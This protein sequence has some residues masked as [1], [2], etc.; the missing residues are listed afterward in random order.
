MSSNNG[1]LYNGTEH[2]GGV[3]ACTNCLF[4][5][6]CDGDHLTSLQWHISGCTLVWQSS[7]KFESAVLCFSAACALG[8]SSPQSALD[9][10]GPG[11]KVWPPSRQ[12]VL[13]SAVCS[14][15]SSRSQWLRGYA[16][17]FS[18]FVKLPHGLHVLYLGP[19]RL[20]CDV[21]FTQFYFHSVS[22]LSIKTLWAL[23]V[24]RP[25]R[26]QTAFLCCMRNAT[27]SSLCFIRLLSN[28]DKG[29]NDPFVR[30]QPSAPL[31]CGFICFRNLKVKIV[32]I[33][34]KKCC[35]FATRYFQCARFPFCMMWFWRQKS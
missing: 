2:W 23:I 22:I 8:T 3:S 20:H 13:W 33:K 1:R 19:L 29:G 5:L 10:L 4:P 30:L 34:R 18:P 9:R 25:S 27:E 14:T 12:G 6:G 21:R 24:H 28:W 15:P 31:V 11:S 32:V 26:V 35:C 7:S 16:D 17:K